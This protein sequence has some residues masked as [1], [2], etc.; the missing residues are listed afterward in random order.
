MITLLAI[1][2]VKLIIPRLEAE[3]RKSSGLNLLTLDF[4]YS[5]STGHHHAINRTISEAAKSRNL[6]ACVFA[7]RY[8]DD[9]LVSSDFRPTFRAG[10]YSMANDTCALQKKWNRIIR[11]TSLDLLMAGIDRLSLDTVI[12]M[13][14]TTAAHVYAVASILKR[15]NLKCRMEVYLMFPPDFDVSPGIVDVQKRQYLSAYQL[16]KAHNASSRFWCENPALARAYRDIGLG[17]VQ[18]MSLPAPIPPRTFAQA[19]VVSDRPVAL[20]IGVARLDRGIDLVVNC[21]D[22][23]LA[24]SVQVT[25]RLLVSSISKEHVRQLAKYSPNVLQYEVVDYIPEDVYF[26]EIAMADLVLLPYKPEQYRLRN[27]NSVTEALGLG[28]PVIVPPGPNSLLDYCE[29]Q[30]AV[31]HVAMNEYSATGLAEAIQS[32]MECL[33]IISANAQTRAE[34]IRRERSPE[35]FLSK[36]FN[37]TS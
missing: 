32:A 31:C 17:T 20:F 18:P 7:S 9:K 12:F 21:L 5:R 36:L 4:S 22:D 34:S 23:L 11:S 8:I 35:I 14:T 26:D 6:N 28:V 13:H 24:K 10:V 27:S 3:G 2:S 16:V 25:V 37:A 15:L 30:T 33:K 19:N 29:M 1:K